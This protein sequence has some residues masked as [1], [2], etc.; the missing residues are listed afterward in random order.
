MKAE[1]VGTCPHPNRGNE[2]A[3]LLHYGKG[4]DSTT[5][6]PAQIE[7]INFKCYTERHVIMRQDY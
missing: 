4:R 1:I 6:V 5:S 3:A 7:T 2:L